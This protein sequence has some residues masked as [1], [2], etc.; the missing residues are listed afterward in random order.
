MSDTKR[1]RAALRGARTRER[2]VHL[3]GPSDRMSAKRKEDLRVE[4]GDTSLS[5]AYGGIPS[6]ADFLG[7]AHLFEREATSKKT[8]RAYIAPQGVASLQRGSLMSLFWYRRDTHVAPLV[9]GDKTAVQGVDGERY[10]LVAAEDVVVASDVRL[11]GQSFMRLCT[12]SARFWL[13]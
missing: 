5:E 1:S 13:K 10:E 3:H 12:G 9:A 4:R 11:G 2:R 7:Q 8:D 6:R